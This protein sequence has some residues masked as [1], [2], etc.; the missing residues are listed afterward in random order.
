MGLFN[1]IKNYFSPLKKGLKA[2]SEGDYDEA[3]KIAAKNYKKNDGEDSLKLVEELRK[4][5][6]SSRDLIFLEAMVYT[7]LDNMKMALEK[8]DKFLEL[9]PDNVFSMANRMSLLSTL[10][11]E[12]EAFEYLEYILDNFDDLVWNDSLLHHFG[13]LGID[14]EW[15]YLGLIHSKIS[16]LNQWGH[17]EE[18]MKIIDEFLELYPED[19]SF[20]NDK[21]AAYY[22][23]GDYDKSLYYVDKALKQCYCG[24]FLNNKADNLAEL[25]RHEEAVK[26]Y[27]EAL[28]FCVGQERILHSQAFSLIALGEYKLAYKNFEMLVE[29]LERTGINNKHGQKM[30]DDA[31]EQMAILE[32]KMKEKKFKFF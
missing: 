9:E 19:A 25:G 4:H 15:I 3:Y 27:D 8:F 14:K 32:E 28:V 11:H 31:L 13:G 2:I 5:G 26:I 17:C 16:F 1:S 12:K 24:E 7:L 18:A 30:Y 21:S 10:G 29:G 20:L 22:F 23:L 6:Y